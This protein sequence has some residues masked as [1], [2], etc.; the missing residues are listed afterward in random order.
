[1]GNMI[2]FSLK[3]GYIYIY[4]NIYNFFEIHQKSYSS[5]SISSYFK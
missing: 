4:I 1:M 5:T 2:G 3:F